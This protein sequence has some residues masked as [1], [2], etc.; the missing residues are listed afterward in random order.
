MTSS[1]NAEKISLTPPSTLVDLYK[2]LITNGH[3]YLTRKNGTDIENFVDHQYHARQMVLPHLFEAI[4]LMH[5]NPKLK[6][7]Q[8]WTSSRTVSWDPMSSIERQ[9]VYCVRYVTNPIDY[10]RPRKSTTTNI[11]AIEKADNRSGPLHALTLPIDPGL[12]RDLE[13]TDENLAEFMKD[14]QFPREF[15]DDRQAWKDFNHF[16]ALRDVNELLLSK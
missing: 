16:S 1:N 8:L 14:R 15:F 3:E 7:A 9:M 13:V 11:L 10:T 2:H 12:N 6:R 5:A 4:W